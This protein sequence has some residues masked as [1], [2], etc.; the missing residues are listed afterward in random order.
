M[1]KSSQC[2]KSRP[3]DDLEGG[4]QLQ[5]TRNGF[6]RGDR[7]MLDVCTFATT[8]VSVDIGTP[9]GFEAWRESTSMYFV[10]YFPHIF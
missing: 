4:A 8:M 10:D 9:I 2:L 1:S 6:F 7:M 5:T 3:R